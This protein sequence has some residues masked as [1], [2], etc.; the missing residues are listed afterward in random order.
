M[1]LK[2]YLKHAPKWTSA[3]RKDVISLLR[4]RA[5]CNRLQVI[6]IYIICICVLLSSSTPKGNHRHC[7]MCYC[8]SNC[9]TVYW[10]WYA[11]WHKEITELNCLS[12][13][14]VIRKLFTFSTSSQDPLDGFW[15]NLVGYS[16]SL[17]SVVV[18]Q[19]GPPR[20]RSRAGPK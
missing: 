18:F 7:I 13:S 8:V 9:V 4:N 3:G 10:I 12:S 20:G 2:I 1:H 6:A 11:R 14:S 5:M 16:W 15:W 17:T 19:S